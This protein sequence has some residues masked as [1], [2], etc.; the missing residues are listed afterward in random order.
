MSF[1]LRFA[2]Y[3][4]CTTSREL[5]VLCPHFSALAAA[6]RLAAAQVIFPVV[7]KHVPTPALL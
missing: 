5:C 3:I 7:L 2:P 6:E 4:R 1:E